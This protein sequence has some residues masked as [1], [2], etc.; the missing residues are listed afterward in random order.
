M[1]SPG[2]SIVKPLFLCPTWYNRTLCSGVAIRISVC[3][4][5]V[6]LCVLLSVTLYGYH[7]VC[8]MT[9]QQIIMHVW[10]WPHDVDVHLLFCFDLD[11]PRSCL[12]HFLDRS[13]LWGITSRAAPSNSYDFSTNYRYDR[14]DIMFSGCPSI[15]PSVCPYFTG[16][17][18]SSQQNL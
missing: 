11:L 9:F 3:P 2:I 4:S 18:C 10:Q 5:F 12:T 8:S 7:F 6:Q 15:H 17:T 1:I 13:S 14:P 16:I